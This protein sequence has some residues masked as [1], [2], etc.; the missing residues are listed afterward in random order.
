MNDLETDAL[1]VGPQCTDR[2]LLK[3]IDEQLMKRDINSIKFLC[4]DWLIP[5]VELETIK[6]GIDLFSFFEKR[7]KGKDFIAECMYRIQRADLLKKLGY[8]TA[9]FV[10]IL[11][12]KGSEFPRFR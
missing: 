3:K 9:Q 12:T 2:L 8:T 6:R 5:E 11:K 7:A 1:G 10:N 4:R